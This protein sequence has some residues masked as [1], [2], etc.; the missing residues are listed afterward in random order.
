MRKILML[1]AAVLAL[2]GCKEKASDYELAYEI[3][4]DDQGNFWIVERE[5]M[6]VVSGSPVSVVADVP[7]GGVIDVDT[8]R[9][10]TP[11]PTGGVLELGTLRL[12]AL[13]DQD[14]NHC[15]SAKNQRCGTALIR[16]F[17]TNPLGGFEV[18]KEDGAYRAIGVGTKHA[19]VLERLAIPPGQEHLR[20]TDYVLGSYQVRLNPGAQGYDTDLVIEYALAP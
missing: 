6:R 13:A 19:T 11:L 2:G 8:T 12:N 16:I 7:G 4:Y 14:L 17:T 15:G 20:I 18:A 1:L 10:G 9:L 3:L 5:E